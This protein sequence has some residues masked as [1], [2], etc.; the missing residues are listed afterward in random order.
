MNYMYNNQLYAPFILSLLS[1]HTSQGFG[2][3]NSPLSGGG[4][5]YAANGTCYTSKGPIHS[6]LNC[7][8]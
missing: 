2:R 5:I 7:A 1:S 6:E 4:I 8:V 3:I